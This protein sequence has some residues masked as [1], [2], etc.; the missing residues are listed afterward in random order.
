[1]FYVSGHGYE[2]TS[3]TIFHWLIDDD[4]TSTPK[5]KTKSKRL[6][7]FMLIRYGNNYNKI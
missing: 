5:E 1:M 4:I 3:I 6:T 2:L 7:L